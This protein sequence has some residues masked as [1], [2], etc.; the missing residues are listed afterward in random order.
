MVSPSCQHRAGAVRKKIAGA[1]FAGWL[2]IAA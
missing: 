1:G 2:G